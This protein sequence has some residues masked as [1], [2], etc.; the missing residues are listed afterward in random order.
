[1]RFEKG[2]QK[3]KPFLC[4][5]YPLPV[6]KRQAEARDLMPLL[7]R[8]DEF[9]KLEDVTFGQEPPDFV[10]DHA[11]GTI[12]VELT[13]LNPKIFEKGGHQRRAN[14]KSFEAEVAQ[15]SPADAAFNWG[16]GSMRDSL[17]AFKT[18]L[19]RKKKKAQ[20]WFANFT[21]RWLLMHAA[22]GSLF[23]KFLNAEHHTTPD[24]ANEEDDFLPKR[25]TPFIRFARRLTRL[26]TLSCFASRNTMQ[27]G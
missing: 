4:K 15:T 1:V 3:V 11:G 26:I 27:R 24:M 7:R 13:D 25:R 2:Q 6:P 17:G 8:L 16:T 12:G 19:E 23:S 9:I 18:Q 5:S 22:S 10:F 21:E 20:P 14:Y